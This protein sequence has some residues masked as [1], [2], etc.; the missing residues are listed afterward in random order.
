[1]CVCVC[2]CVCVCKEGGGGVTASTDSPGWLLHLKSN[3]YNLLSSPMLQQH[4]THSNTRAIVC[5]VFVWC[6]FLSISQHFT[7]TGVENTSLATKVKMVLLCYRIYNI[8]II[9]WN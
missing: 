5:C 6:V 2:V 4:S 1:M 9:V 8:I 7:S 3:N